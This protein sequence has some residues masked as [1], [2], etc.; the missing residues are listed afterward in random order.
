MSTDTWTTKEG[1][2]IPVADMT[3]SHLLNAHKFMVNRYVALS[4]ED[5]DPETVGVGRLTVSIWVE[6]FEEEIERRKLDPLVDR[7]WYQWYDLE[8]F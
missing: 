5:G 8:H 6:R 1:V 7:E 3:D 4:G 2:K